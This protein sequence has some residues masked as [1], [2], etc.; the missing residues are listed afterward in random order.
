MT[1]NDMEEV[2]MRQIGLLLKIVVSR[3]VKTRIFNDGISLKMCYKDDKFL[4]TMDTKKYLEERNQLVLDFI[5]GCCGINYREQSDN[6]MLFTIAVAV[7]MI[8]FIRNLN[9]V[10]PH[11]FII[12]LWQSFVSGFKKVSTLNGKVTAG[13]RYTAYKSWVLNFGSNKIGKYVIKNYRVTSQK[14][15]KADIITASLHLSLGGN[16]L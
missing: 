4:K 6:L 2:H 3:L 7:E 5:N 11:C 9:L 8:Y 14:T 12:N 13:A 10:L 1:E 16:K 15:K